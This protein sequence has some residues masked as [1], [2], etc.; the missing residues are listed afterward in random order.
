MT[1][2]PRPPDRVALRTGD[3]LRIDVSAD[4]DGFLTVFNIGPTGHLNLLH[5]DPASVGAAPAPVP[6]NR[7]LQNLEVVMTPPAGNERLFAFWSQAP[8]PLQQALQWTSDHARHGSASYQATRN[9]ERVQESVQRMQRKDWHA[10]V[11]ELDH[12]G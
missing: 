3:R 5:P 6:A 7:P 12:Q 4:R 2:V 8:L 10:V 11:L 1:K 9:M